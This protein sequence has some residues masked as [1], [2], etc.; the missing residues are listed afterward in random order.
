MGG[1]AVIYHGHIRLTGDVDFYYS[2]ESA[3]AAR[4]HSALLDFWGGDVPGI[5]RAGELEEPG[6][7]LQ[8]GRPP[9]R[10][11]LL[12]RVSGVE[13]EGAWDARLSLALDDGTPIYY[14]SLADLMA[15]KRATGR[16][17]DL[18]DLA[19][20]RRAAREQEGQGD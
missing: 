19:Y 9:N 8:F 4:L 6:L 12:N 18:E 3:N 10:I 15:N 14:I 20:L 17:K 7:V 13:F 2:G 16:P 1:E 11:D 5:G